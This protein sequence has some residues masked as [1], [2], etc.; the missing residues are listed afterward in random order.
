[1]TFDGE[2]GCVYWITGLAGAG[3]TTLANALYRNMR[4]SLNNVVILDGDELRKSIAFDLG[5]TSEER[6]MA[7]MR[8]AKLSFMLAMQGINVVIGTI[9]MF[10]DVRKWNRE[11]IEKYCEIYLK[12]PIEVLRQRNQKCLYTDAAQGNT[13]NVYG[14]DMEAEEPLNPDILII[15]DGTIGVEEC[16]KIIKAKKI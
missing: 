4:Q 3:K 5:Y 8:Y 9:S 14:V 7:A 15:N 11:N 1:M 12:V 10:H 16:V 2:K 6:K 13:Q